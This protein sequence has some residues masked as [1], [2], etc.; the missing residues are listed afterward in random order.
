[1][2]L[3][4]IGFVITLAAPFGVEAQGP[5]PL[6]DTECLGCHG[7]QDASVTLPSGEPLSLFVNGPKFAQSVHGQKSVKCVDCHTDITSFPHPPMYSRTRRDVTLL[8]Y[9]QCRK[10]H[11]GN[12]S[13]SLDGV[14][15]KAIAAGDQQAAVCTDCHG[16]HEVTKP[17]QPRARIPQTCA[18]CHSTIYDDY[19]KTV[20]GAALLDDSNPDVP[21]CVDCHGIHNINDPTTVAFRLKSP[22]LCARCHTDDKIMWKYK[23]STN[24]LNT[25]V[26]DFHGTTVELFE[27]QSPDAATNKPV[28]FDCHGIHNIKKVDDPESTVFRKGNLL[29]TCQRCH[30]DATADSFTAAWMSHYNAS[31][32]KYPLVY[33]VNLF[34]IILVPGTIGAMLL[35]IALDVYRRVR[36]RLAH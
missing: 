10:C 13:K 2:S 3:L 11:E 12:Y 27:K 15:S 32:D 5:K 25:Y 23:I 14:H 34:Y 26:A 35:Y 9:T 19:A 24:V 17:N 6:T 4:V 20:H 33:Y 29:K 7:N 36:G 18:Q 21:T 28:C 16:A 22:E 31:A 30:P 8:K 1:M